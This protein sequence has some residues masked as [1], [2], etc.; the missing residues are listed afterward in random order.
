MG[1]WCGPLVWALGEGGRGEGGR[2]GE[3]E[4]GGREGGRGEG[5]GWRGEGRERRCLVGWW[6]GPPVLALGEGGRG[7]ERGRGGGLGWVG[8][9]EEVPCGMVVWSTGLGPR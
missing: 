8:E 7:R 3:R 5:G 2:E 4:E 6:C 1:W 9:G